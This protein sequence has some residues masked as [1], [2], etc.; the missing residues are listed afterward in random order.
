M[1]M[2]Y[3]DRDLAERLQV[4]LETVRY[5]RK[6]GTGP[7]AIKV[8]RAVRYRESDVQVWLAEHTET[9]RVVV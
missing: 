7:R 2:L 5:W 9:K 1:E 8:G 6:K 4:S 3:T